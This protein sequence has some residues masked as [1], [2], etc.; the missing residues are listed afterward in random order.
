METNNS[1]TSSNLRNIKNKTNLFGSIIKW[2]SKGDEDKETFWWNIFYRYEVTIGAIV[3]SI[4]ALFIALII[5]PMIGNATLSLIYNKKVEGFIGFIGLLFS[6]LMYGTLSSL[7]LSWLMV[8]PFYRLFRGE[9]FSP[10]KRIEIGPARVGFANLLSIGG[11]IVLI[12]AIIR[13]CYKCIYISNVIGIIIACLFLILL[14]VTAINAIS[15]GNWRFD[16]AIENQGIIYDRHYKYWTSEVDFA[17]E[18]MQWKHLRWYKMMVATVLIAGPSILGTSY[19][20]TTQHSNKKNKTTKV[21][22]KVKA[23]ALNDNKYNHNSNGKRNLIRYC[24]NSKNYGYVNVREMPSTNSPVVKEIYDG[25][26]FYG[27][28]LQDNPDWIEYIDEN[29]NVI[30][31]VKYDCVKKPGDKGYFYEDNESQKEQ[32]EFK[33]EVQANADINSSHYHFSGYM[34]DDKGDHPIELD[35]DASNK[36]LTN[37]VYKNVTLGGKIHMKC[38]NFSGIYMAQDGFGG[39]SEYL[40]YFTIVG[41]DGPKDFIMSMTRVGNCPYEGTAAV[42]TKHLTVTLY[43]E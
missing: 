41:K 40:D 39:Y 36:G 23:G 22:N 33:H 34:T 43:L 37:I 20:L 30:G 17:S 18:R 26:S 19:V 38:T 5:F 16:W 6:L 9:S 7:F 1:K 4:I 29:N 25:E 12:Y 10:H 24:I 31:Y 32:E 28:R 42:G 3:G 2:F 21:E 8:L 11:I 27:N 35:F 13:L 14:I 15:Y